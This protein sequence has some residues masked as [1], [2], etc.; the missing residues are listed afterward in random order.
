[1]LY[2]FL[3]NVAYVKTEQFSSESTVK[4][5]HVKCLTVVTENWKGS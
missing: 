3:K 5:G 1:M 4:V 2:P